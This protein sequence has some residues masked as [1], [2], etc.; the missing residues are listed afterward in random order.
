MQ[1][2]SESD[3]VRWDEVI[4]VYSSTKKEKRS[5]VGIWSF[6]GL[7][8]FSSRGNREALYIGYEE[9]GI[10]PQCLCSRCSALFCLTGSP[11]DI[12]DSQLVTERV[13]RCLE[14]HNWP[15]GHT[16]LCCTVM[17]GLILTSHPTKDKSSDQQGKH[18]GLSTK[19]NLNRLTSYLLFNQKDWSLQGRGLCVFM[20]HK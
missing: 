18:L 19:E 14:R 16:A 20:S 11:V 9:T 10:S 15:K 13:L 7:A 5:S 12:S 1:Q 8:T 6:N 17:C 2:L 3:E 4:L